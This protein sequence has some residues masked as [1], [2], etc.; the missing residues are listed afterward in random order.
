M[1]FSELIKLSHSKSNEHGVVKSA[2]RSSRQMSHGDFEIYSKSNREL[3]EQAVPVLQGVAGGGGM[4]AGSI[5]LITDKEGTVL[6]VG[7]QG[8]V[9]DF[10][11]CKGDCLSESTL[12]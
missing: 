8:S 2:K 1:D 12:R 10:E 9:A 4:F 3:L 6:F 5:L 7:G 11:V